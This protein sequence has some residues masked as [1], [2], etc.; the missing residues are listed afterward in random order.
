MRLFI[1]FTILRK[2]LLETLRDRRTIFRMILLPMLLYPVFALGLSKLAGSEA[3]AREARASRVAVWGELPPVVRAAL[4]GPAMIDA[5]GWRGAPPALRRELAAGLHAPVRAPESEDDPAPG[6]KRRA[7]PWVEPENPVFDAARDALARREVDAVLVPWP[8]FAAAIEGGQ[9]GEVSIYFDAVRPE[10]GLARERLDQALRKART[11]ARAL[12]E[13]ARALP[14]GFSETLGILDRNVAP[15]KRSAGQLLGMMMP[16]LVITMSLLGGFLPAIDL[17]AG[18]KERGTMQTLLCAPLRS[19]EIIAGKF[20]AVFIISLLAAVANLASLSFTIRRLIPFDIEIPVSTY[21]LTFAVMLPVSFFFAALFLAVAAFARDFR[22]GQNAL[23][24]VYLPIVL[25][26]SITALPGFELDAW[27]AFVPVINV[28][29][30]I[31]ALFMGEAHAELIFLVL[32]ASTVWASLAL[33]LAARV[34]EQENVLLGGKEPIRGLFARPKAGALPGTGVALAVYAV[35]LTLTFY[36]SLF[37]EHRGMLWQLLVVEYLF[38]LAP[39]LLVIAYL[40]A[41]L[42]ESLALTVPPLRGLAAAVLIGASGWVLAGASIRILPPPKE[43]V[44]RLS[45]AVLV[46]GRAFPIVLLAIAVTPA[47]CEELFFRGLVLGALK[48]HGALV[49]IVGSALLFA[50]IHGSIYRLLPTFLLGAVMGWV[51][52]TTRSIAPG[53]VVHALNN[54]VAAGLLYFKPRWA[55]TVVEGT[56]L[57]LWMVGVGAVVFATG[58]VALPRRA[59]AA[60]GS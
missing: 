42:R 18:E 13:E 58:L 38:I 51:R 54:G 12:R 35:S 3:D 22:D 31:K 19:I 5:E 57:P 36:G 2:E 4:E 45:N 60:E 1:V 49:A 16:M 11:S 21:A 14:P 55:E 28:A 53:M 26:S 48:R 10:S 40:R 52:V 33:V 32:L 15:P 46:D 20:L 29:L 56:S 9:K 41:P 34:F 24:P 8:G 30:L 17:T 50:L 39:V 7:A 47:V 25:A 43:L 44:E 37:L 6:K 59:R 27:T 23:A